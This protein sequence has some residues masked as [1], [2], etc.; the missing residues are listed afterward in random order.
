MPGAACTAGFFISR[1]PA[2]CRRLVFSDSGLFLRVEIMANFRIIVC[3]LLLGSFSASLQAQTR[4]PFDKPVEP[5]NLK[6]GSSFS[7]S[8]GNGGFDSTDRLVPSRIAAEILEAEEIIRRSHVEGPKI[9]LNDLTKS[10]LDGALKTLDPHSNYFDPAEWKEMLDEEQSSYSGIGAS[11][12]SYDLSGERNTYILATFPGSAA[13]KAQ[14][15]YGDKIV[16]VNGE[17]LLGKESD[18]VRDKLRG[19]DGTVARVTVLRAATDREETVS[20]RRG[21]VPQPSIPDSYMLRPG[22]G[23]IALTEGFNYTTNDEFNAALRTLKGK[24]MRSLVLDLRGNPGGIVDQAVKVVEKFV[25]AQTVIVTQKGRSRLDNRVWRSTN[26]NPETMPLVVLVDENSASASEIVAGALQDQ[27]RALIVGEKTFGKGLVQ[28]VLDLPE[29]S[30]LTLT[31]AR[32]LTP[33]GRSIQRDYSKIGLYDYYNHTTT[34]AAIDKPY[35]EA[36]TVTDRKVFGGDG[37]LPDEITKLPEMNARQISLLDP[38]FFFVKEAV[39]G[40]V[41]G[42]ASP[43]RSVN[44]TIGKRLLPSDFPETT[45]LTSAFASFL[46]SHPELNISGEIA[47]SENSFISLRLRYELAIAYYGSVSASQVLIEDDAQAAKAVEALPRAAQLAQNA[48]RAKQQPR[49]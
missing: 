30:G 21:P 41:A 31:T 5:F 32:Y 6:S 17:R 39:N 16:A 40:R 11:I 12:A 34:A 36:R 47:R 8:G 26:A 3:V 29:R 1:S 10:T 24:G 43:T 18:V 14:L 9:T 27:D 35:F 44:I 19:P 23:Y 15:H 46:L 7:A 33:S 4:S 42:F 37:I 28:S 2:V 49:K 48:A 13:A 38:M 45:A 22:V 20:L 25:P